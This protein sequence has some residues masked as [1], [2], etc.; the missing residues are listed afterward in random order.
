MSREIKSV[1]VLGAG[2]MGTGIAGLAAEK[3]CKVLLLDVS[4]EAAEKALDRIVNG[5]P[6]A[7]DT[8][9]KEANIELGTL[10]D[11]LEKI[12]DY[13]WVC[14]AV[15]EDVETKRKLFERFEPLRKDGSV[16]STNT[17]GIPL[18]DITAGM[19]DRLLKDVAVTHFFNPV[20]IMKLCE[21]VPGEKT[22]PDVIDAFRAF[23]GGVM[24]KGVVNAKDTV[25]FIGNRIG[26]FWM[27]KGLHAATDARKAG[28]SQERIDALMSAPMGLPPTGLYGLIDLIGLDIMD[29]VGKNLAVNLPQGD[30]GLPFN[31]FPAAEQAMLDR[32]QLGRKTG[33]GFYKLTKLDDGSRKKE[34]FDLDAGDWRDAEDVA[35]DATAD[36]VLADTADGQFCWDI[37]GATLSYAAD[38]IPEISDDIVNVDRA[39]RWGF[40]WGKGPF[41]LLDTLGPKA[42]LAKCRANG[43]APKMLEVLESAGAE[44]FYRKDGTEFL[45]L[46][47]QYHPV[48]AE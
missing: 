19:P 24:G 7:I 10:A 26:C 2:T 25:N 22:D 16:V 23:L 9:G 8:P 34:T 39:M 28:L 40:A 33:G 30:A 38:L 29:F 18:R 13:D 5:R 1:A 12:A 31:K 17:S 36:V 6:L 4:M 48:P 11:D 45:G 27:L 20:K 15:I 41:E 47:G 44:T 14:E 21:V 37:M 43:T 46:D 35:V 42:F 32:G 3:D